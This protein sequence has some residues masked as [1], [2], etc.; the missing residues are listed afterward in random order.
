M[1]VAGWLLIRALG[2]ACHAVQAER[3]PEIVRAQKLQIREAAEQG[4][5]RFDS[6]RFGSSQSI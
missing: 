5:T 6:R 1:G 2:A 3:E 4:D